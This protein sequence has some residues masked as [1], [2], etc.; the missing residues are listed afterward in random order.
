[1]GGSN[2][3]I[4]T[5]DSKIIYSPMLPDSHPDCHFDNTQR[6]HEEL[7]YDPS[8][9]KGGCGFSIL[10]PKTGESKEL[11]PAQEGCWD[12]RPRLSKDGKWLL[13]THNE[14]GKAGEIKL[15]NMETG[16]IRFITNGKN[17]LGADHAAFAE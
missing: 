2:C 12:F 5:P 13:Y 7:I 16:D 3:P 11:T 9:G 6:D 15:R 4:W 17:G 14:F 1:M 8:M 10:D